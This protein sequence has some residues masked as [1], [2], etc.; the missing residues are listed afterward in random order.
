MRSVH[1]IEK[2]R[3]YH[4]KDVMHMFNI[5]RVFEY[6]KDDDG[7]FLRLFIQTPSWYLFRGMWHGLTQRKTLYMETICHNK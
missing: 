4:F 2:L 6:R 5:V 3:G 1:I 7:T